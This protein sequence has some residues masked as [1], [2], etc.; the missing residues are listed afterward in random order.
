VTMRQ[1]QRYIEA[2]RKAGAMVRQMR[3]LHLFSSCVFRERIQSVRLGCL[4]TF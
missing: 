4:G 2:A 1:R 3:Q